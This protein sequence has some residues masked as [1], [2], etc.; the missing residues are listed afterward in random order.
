MSI[1][2]GARW[3]CAAGCALLLATCG[4]A[5]DATIEEPVPMPAPSPIEYPVALWDRRVEGET[6]VLIHVNVYGDV[7][8]ALVSKTS[9]YAE[10]DSAAVSGARLLRFTPGRRGDRH[11]AMWTKIPVRFSQDSSAVLGTGRSS[12]IRE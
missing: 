3:C 2:N 5:A 12:G 9:G 8:S 7:D 4:D 6:E 10:F 1:R 11:A